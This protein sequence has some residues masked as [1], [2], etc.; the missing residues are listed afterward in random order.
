MIIY[1]TINKISGKWY[2]GKDSSNRPYYFG[3]GVALRNALKKYGKDNFEKI[4]LEVCTS[5]EQLIER[6]KFWI[7]HTNATTDPM[8]YNLAKGGEGGDLSKFID[9][10]SRKPGDRFAGAQKWYSS[11][12]ENEKESLQRN[13]ALKRTKGWY[14]STVDNPQEIYVQ[15]INAWCKE[16]GVDSSMP[17]SLNNPNSHLFLKQTKGWRIRRA[18][19]PVLPPYE[20]NRGK[21]KTDN[22]CV[23][24]TW[25]II[26][27]KRVWTN[28]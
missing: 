24:K 14:V 20:N 27:G 22:G 28:K 10:T 6:E 18:D 4:I 13:R 26:D 19:M 12:S 11:L 21:V 16:H 17:S 2:I 25:K 5:K 3:S 9:Y 1:K 15:N 7:A 23:G 8:S